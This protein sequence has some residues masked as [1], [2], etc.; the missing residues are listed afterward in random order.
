VA[1]AAY[2]AAKSADDVKWALK[3]AQMACLAVQ[4]AAPARD[5]SAGRAERQWQQDRLPA[6]ARNLRWL[7]ERF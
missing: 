6:E 4:V 7:T 3:A 1:R 5:T 2:F